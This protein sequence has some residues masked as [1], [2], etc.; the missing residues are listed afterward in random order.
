MHCNYSC[1]Q[2]RCTALHIGLAGI[3]SSISMAQTCIQ[4]LH[5]TDKDKR[6]VNTVDDPEPLL[7]EPEMTYSIAPLLST[8]AALGYFI[9]PSDAPFPA[10]Q[11]SRE[12]QAAASGTPESVSHMELGEQTVTLS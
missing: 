1:T 10:R 4:V 8:P 5:N 6:H 3:A 2:A 11:T 9:S 7:G 12:H